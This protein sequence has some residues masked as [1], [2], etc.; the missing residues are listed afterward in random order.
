MHWDRDKKETDIQTHIHTHTDTHTQTHTTHNTH[1]QWYGLE[2]E[3]ER[4]SGA[5]DAFKTK[6]EKKTS[7][8]LIVVLIVRNGCDDS[9]YF[10]QND[11]WLL[12]KKVQI[13][14]FIT[15]S[16]FSVLEETL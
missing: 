11:L 10:G 12:R 7:V 2:R 6:A 8:D 3:K 1:T 14:C 9:A 15:N 16:F 5:E 13:F 4:K